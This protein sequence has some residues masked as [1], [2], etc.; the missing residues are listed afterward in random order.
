MI[1]IGR[2]LP[3]LGVFMLSMSDL[4]ADQ[5]SSKPTWAI[6]VHGG[7]GG[8]L[9][10]LEAEAQQAKKDGLKIA[11]ERGQTILAQGGSAFLDCGT[12]SP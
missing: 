1:S 6:A 5:P 8:N 7:A 4:S 11:L 3:F 12:L 10:K 2:F 9:L